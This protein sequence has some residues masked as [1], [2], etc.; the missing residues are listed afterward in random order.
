MVP[1]SNFL[2][3][4]FLIFRREWFSIAA[5]SVFFEKMYLKKSDVITIGLRVDM[6]MKKNKK[7]STNFYV[8]MYI[9]IPRSS[10]F[11][12]TENTNQFSEKSDIISSVF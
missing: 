1:V 9:C 3:M 4:N 12:I 7:N 5:K 11:F 8:Y 10:F 6:I 2:D